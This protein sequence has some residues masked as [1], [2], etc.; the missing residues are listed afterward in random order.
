MK[1]FCIFAFCK[2]GIIKVAK[3][4]L[5]KLLVKVIYD[6]KIFGTDIHIYT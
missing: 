2:T 6:T 3:F 4:L 1:C 5:K